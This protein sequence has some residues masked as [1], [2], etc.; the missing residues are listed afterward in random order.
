MVRDGFSE[1]IQSYLSED[2]W[3]IPEESYQAEEN[4]KY[5]SIFC[6]SNGYIGT[7]G[8]HEEGTGKSIPCTYINGV[9]DKSEAFM[10]ELVNLP[11]WVGIKLYFEKELLG[12][13]NCR[14][15]EYVRALDMKKSLL[16]KHVLLEDC[17]GK[18]TLIEGIRFVSRSERHCMGIR[19]FVTPVNYEGILEGENIIDGTVINFCDAPRFKVKHTCMVSNHV[20]FENGIYQE[21]AT[22]ER[23]LHVGTGCCITAQKDGKD[24]IKSHAVH[25]FGEQSVEFFDMN[26]Q[27]GEQI[28]ITKYCSIFTEREDPEDQILNKVKETV[29]GFRIRGFEKELE[30]HCKIY[31][32]MWDQADI[33]ISGDTETN[34]AVR[35]NIY[36]LMSAGNEYD[37]HVNIGAKF[38][39]GEE[40]GGHTFWD[41]ELFMLPF[42]AYVFPDTAKNLELYRSHLLDAAR[43]NATK[44]GYR[45]AQYPWESA[46]D[47][48]EQ[49]PEW[50]IEPDGSC[51]RCYVADYEHHVTAAV[52]YGIYNYVKIVGDQDFMMRYGVEILSETARFWASRSEYNEAG[53]RYEIRGVTGPDEWHEPVNNNLY[54]NYLAKW[55]LNYAHGLLNKMKKEDPD[56][57]A[58]L[59]KKIGLSTSELEAWDEIQKKMYLPRQEGTCLLEQFE[60][61]FDLKEVLIRNYDGNDWPIKPEELGEINKE[62]TQI[63]K[64]AD[65][66]MLLYLLGEQFD[67]KTIRENYNYYEKR[68]LHGSSLSP[69]IY[70]IMGLKVGDDRKAYRYLKR[71]ATL[72]LLDLQKNTREGIHAANMGGVW[73]TVVCGFGGLGI[74]KDG[75]LFLNP[76]LPEQ[77]NQLKFR[78]HYHST[79]LEFDIYKN[80]ICI[81]RLSGLPLEIKVQGEKRTV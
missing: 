61:Y 11:N 27:M 13:E 77:W 40:Y 53:S 38:L 59:Q 6:L 14:V 76:S 43:K 2:C 44:N 45:G 67:E 28:E 70:S 4:L 52:A 10:R 18:K 35:F 26:V 60:G 32:K 71:A 62:D 51:Y 41:T 81:T 72:D 24:I 20:L 69:S 68:T 39:H 74:D 65:V 78:V 16:A 73:Q 54:T 46:D 55:N 23:N 31:E 36:H 12:I 80:Q 19:L 33:I 56:T 21:V 7:R 30:N 17:H 47:G 15:L 25:S 58:Q 22:R 79:W 5:E 37:S 50:T 42:F 3:L 49:C 57:Y 64:Q 8:C 34:K 9:F 63:I 66:V 1:K 75:I 48:T 29:D